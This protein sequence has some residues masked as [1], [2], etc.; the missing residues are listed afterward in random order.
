[1]VFSSAV[2]L[3]VFLPAVFLL[4][5]LLPGIRAKNALLLIASLIFYAFGQPVYLPLLLLS[6]LLNYVC[7]RMAAGKHARLGV[8]LAVIGGIGM[9]A[10]FKY[11]DFLIGSLN[12]AFGLALPLTGIALPIGISFFTFQGLSYVIDVYRDRTVVSRSFVKVLLYI[13]YFPQLIAGPIVK[14]HDIEKEIDNRRTTPQETAHGIRRFIC[15][16]SKKLLLSNAMGR[17]ADAVFTLPAG[18]IGMFAAWMGAI[19]YTLQ[20]YF[21]FSGYSDMAIGMGRMFGFHFQENFNYPYT[22]TTIKEFWRRWHISLSTWFRDYLYVPLGGNRKGRGRTWVNRFLVFFA[23]GL[24]HGASWNFVLWGLWHGTFSVLEDSGVL[25]VQRLRGRL[26]GRIYTLLVV[27]L[28]F[29]LFRADTLAQAGAMFS[30]MFTGVGLNWAGTAAVCALLTPSFLL[31]LLV[32]L[33]LSAPVAK[34]LEP[35]R[36]WITLAGSLVLLVLCMLDLSAG[37]FNPFIYFRF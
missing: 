32:S 13:A 21:D 22:A 26:A 10:V 24:W 16:L 31:C 36:E 33:L 7:G 6:V 25:P 28:G 3:F 18:E 29:T 37:T 27:V 23:T 30:A 1:M 19:C 5:R 17:M 35:K 20:I 12:S 11:A 15:G 14:Y 2:F 4:D 8:A 9:L 34:R